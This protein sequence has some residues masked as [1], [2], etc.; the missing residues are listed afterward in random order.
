MLEAEIRCKLC[1]K[2][3]YHNYLLKNT[4]S[5]D[6]LT[7]RWFH[8][9][10]GC[11]FN[12]YKPDKLKVFTEEYRK[13]FENLKEIRNRYDWYIRNYV[14]IVEEKTYGRKF[15][16]VG[17]CVDY[18]IQEMRR[19]GWVATGIDLIPNDMITGDFETFDFGKEQF[20]FIWLGDVLQCFDK[21]MQAL[22]KAYELLYPSGLIFIVTPNTDLIREGKISAWGHWNIEENR[23]FFSLDL[24]KRMIQKI[25]M[26][27]NGN[28]RI[29]YADNNYSQRFPSWNNI[30]LL[31]Q[32]EKN[33]GEDLPV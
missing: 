33:E 14:T 20:D 32:K 12:L 1:G 8:C 22:W 27:M 24:L 25:D 4:Q 5:E 13:Q 15:L 29:I 3:V 17:F 23:Q 19:R 11:A 16:D 26:Q 7:S 10:C 6:D 31:C 21:P 2:P 9:S 30:H 28:L 18:I